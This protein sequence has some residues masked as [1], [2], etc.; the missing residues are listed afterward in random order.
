MD[1]RRDSGS[2]GGALLAIKDAPR[3]DPKNTDQTT[4]EI[5]D[6][7]KLADLTK[8]VAA[9]FA[10]LSAIGTF[11]GI[12][13]GD[14]DAIIRARPSET[15]YIACLVGAGVVG[16]L[17][18]SAAF[19]KTVPFDRVVVIWAAMTLVSSL[20]FQDFGDDKSETSRADI[21]F[22]LVLIVASAALIFFLG[23]ARISLVAA[24]VLV[25]LAAVCL[26]LYGAVKLA[27][28]SKAGDADTQVSAKVVR[29]DKLTSVDVKVKASRLREGSNLR[30]ELRG[31]TSD[32]PGDN[33]ELLGTARLQSTPNGSLDS[34]A[35]FPVELERWR[36][37]SIRTCDPTP[38]DGS[39]QE[40]PDPQ[41]ECVADDERSRFE[42]GDGTALAPRISGSLTTS[43][44]GFVAAFSASG[45]KMTEGVHLVSVELVK[46]GKERL[47]SHATLVPDAKGTEAWTATVPIDAKDRGSLVLRAEECEVNDL[48]ACT[49]NQVLAT[50]PV[51]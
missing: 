48:N 6:P 1:L 32:S 38:S 22:Y 12:K 4:Q 45:Q 14:L 46:S 47:L 43:E 7:S 39:D 10:A 49:N 26:G 24:G 21:A 15:L 28:G 44:K 41:H 29:G 13:D 19:S 35:S 11:F 9:G 23:S 3:Q 2:V 25:A 36:G 42:S 16:A 30:V 8:W 33:G 18:A 20:V 40:A 5:I 17:V 50:L 34:S 37:F 31:I 27:I 51:G